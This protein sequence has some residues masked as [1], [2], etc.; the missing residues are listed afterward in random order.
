MLPHP[1]RNETSWQEISPQP[2]SYRQD[3]LEQIKSAHF[4]Q[5]ALWERA[6]LG[7]AMLS[8]AQD[9]SPLLAKIPGEYECQ[10]WSCAAHSLWG[11]F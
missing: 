3:C 7:R 8:Y 6:R 2:L 10:D 4:Q 9:F 1:F 11:S 5:S